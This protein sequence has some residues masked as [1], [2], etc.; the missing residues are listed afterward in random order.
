MKYRSAIVFTLAALAAMPAFGQQPANPASA[1]QP[2]VRTTSEEVV[3]DVIVRDKKGKPVTDLK[4]G[5]LTVLDNGTRQELASFRLVQGA[6]AIS[7]GGAKT[8]LDPL[9]QLRLVTLAFEALGGVDQRNLA[10][11]AALD[12]IKG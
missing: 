12:L 10:R 9:R 4:P 5:E 3:L 1:P 7:Q 11:K 6:E 8:R 2:T